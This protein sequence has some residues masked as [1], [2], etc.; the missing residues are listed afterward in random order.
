MPQPDD[1]LVKREK[2]AAEDHP[3]EGAQFAW[4]G[5][6]D[7]H[8]QRHRFLVVREE[9]D[10]LS[11]VPGTEAKFKVGLRALRWKGAKSEDPKEVPGTFLVVK[12]T[13]RRVDLRRAKA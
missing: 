9:G 5:P 12:T 3:A 11:L 7:A 6:V 1:F 13:A 2:K 10:E 8:D 4:F